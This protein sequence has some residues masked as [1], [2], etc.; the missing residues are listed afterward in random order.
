MSD[1]L[2][3]T[4]KS[5]RNL[6]ISGPI[7]AFSEI[8]K[9]ETLSIGATLKT[10]SF[11][12]TLTLIFIPISVLAF[13]QSA[14]AHAEP[15][16]PPGVPRLVKFS[17]QLKDASGNLLTDTLGVMFAIYT[18][19]TGG[20]PLWQETQNVQFSHGRYTVVL[21]NSTSTGIPAELFASGQSRWLGVK[22]LLSGEEEQPR[23]LLAS[24]PYALKA[25]D[26]DTL[27][28]LPA[29]SYLRTDAV[30]S[31]TRVASV[32]ATPRFSSSSGPLS[33]IPGSRIR[34]TGANGEENGRISISDSTSASYPFT[35]KW[36]APPVC[37][38]TPTSDPHALGGYWVTN[39][40]S[41]VTVNVHYPGRITFNFHCQVATNF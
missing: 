37:T 19:Q 17:A 16:V 28:G 12:V 36:A 41:T 10:F 22:V 34:R 39:S 5:S 8:K 30:N 35:T 25:V 31:V 3:S 23:V 29:S 40:T 26:A 9:N 2:G 20:V 21:G 32:G 11:L 15:D 18:E 7:V 14:Q 13:G 6:A 24:V 38:L 33:T 27:G 4:G 1:R